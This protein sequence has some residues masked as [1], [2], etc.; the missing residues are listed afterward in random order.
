MD[1]QQKWIIIAD[2]DGGGQGKVYR[3]CKKN[4]YLEVQGGVRNA[5]ERFSRSV[6]YGAQQN[7]E[8]H[9]ELRKWLPKMLQMEDPA[10]QFALKVL[11]KTQDA[12]DPKLAKERIKHEIAAM[13]QNLH[14]NLIE[15]V[16]SD[17]DS[18]WFI[19]KFYPGGTLTKKLDTFK[20]DFLSVL[21]AFRP[22][23][24]GV[25]KLHKEGY[26]HRDIKPENI[27]IGAKNE[28]ILGDFGLVFFDD[29][30]H[31]RIS[32]TYQNVGSRDWMPAWAM[33]MRIE[34]IKPTFDVFC[35]GKILWAMTS[36]R[37]VLRLWYFRDDEF[38]VEQIFPQSSTIKFANPLFERCIVE[39]EKSCLPDAGAL[40]N[41]I[42]KTI[43]VIEHG[44]EH[45]DLAVNRKCKVCGR[46]DYALIA[47]EDFTQT[48]N[49]GLN[50]AGN[51]VMKI[52]TCTQCGN[53]QL[54]SY[55]GPL[56]P[57]AWRK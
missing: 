3:V 8:D 21:K 10:N 37:P 39:R 24:E 54:F 44:A 12:R 31:T 33:G 47:D 35:L 28:L 55:N 30:Q 18:E 13:R 34:G 26:V 22:V 23:V 51:R 16:D 36:G 46:G 14:P 49:F 7:S 41:E 11:H 25:A 56:Q 40:L 2:H 43:S 42:D 19:S 27:F 9:K 29:P 50:P 53:V 45:L 1:Y 15:L 38:D 4:E 52:F 5:L 17:P 6:T 32:E 20:G 57:P 48:H